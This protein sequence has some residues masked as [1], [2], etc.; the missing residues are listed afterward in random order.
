MYQIGHEEAEAVRRVIESKQLFRYR[1]GEGGETDQFEAEWAARLGVSHATAVTSGT[2]A[3][4]CGLVGLGIG[5]GDEVIVPAYTWMAT[6]MAALAVGAVPILAEV[7]ASLALDARDVEEK[8]TSRTKAIIPV[9][10]SG[11]PCDMDAIMAVAGRHGL[12]VLEDACQAIGG[13]YRGRALG[14]IGQAGAFSFNHYKIITCGEGGAVVTNDRTVHDRALIYHDMGAAFREHAGSMTV[15]IFCGTNFRMNEILSA[16]LRVQLGRLDGIL[17]ALRQEKKALREELATISAFTFNPVNDL[18]GDCGVVLNLLFE[19]P[20]QAER[21]V[22]R[23]TEI[24]FPVGRAI[25]SGRHVYTNW[26]PVL[27][28]RGSHHPGLDPFRA[29]CAVKYTQ[30]M[31]PRTLEYLACTVTVFTSVDRP[32]G[33]FRGL[34]DAIRRSAEKGD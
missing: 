13:Q 1:G 30:D 32:S 19:S 21:F 10:M 25:D 15:P 8:I 28:Q 6:A 12:P 18:D 22:G 9:H 31:C 26:S 16:I 17:D 7:D 4:I 11:C 34:V 24:G 2:A 29:N 33:A 3:L 5:P 14:S 27:E 20:A 23:M